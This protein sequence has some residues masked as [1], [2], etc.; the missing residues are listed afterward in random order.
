M[1][2]YGSKWQMKSDASII[3]TI[4]QNYSYDRGDYYFWC[5]NGVGRLYKESTLRKYFVELDFT[6]VKSSPR[7][8]K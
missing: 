6:P 2:V 8:L 4:G 5:H 1:I 7:K 3:G